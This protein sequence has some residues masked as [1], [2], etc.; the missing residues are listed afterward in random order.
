MAQHND[1]ISLNAYHTEVGC[2]DRVITVEHEDAH[3]LHQEKDSIAD[4]RI[5]IQ[6]AMQ[7]LRKTNKHEEA[8]EL[9]LKD[10]DLLSK[11]IALEEQKAKLKPKGTFGKIQYALKG[12][13]CTICFHHKEDSKMLYKGALKTEIPSHGIVSSFI[14]NH[15]YLVTS[16]LFALGASLYTFHDYQQKQSEE[17]NFN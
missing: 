17:V 15:P 8:D 5:Q 9:E 4:E 13:Q 1:N 14:K 12:K 7:E 16:G 2:I 6:K 10:F 11:Q 3:Q